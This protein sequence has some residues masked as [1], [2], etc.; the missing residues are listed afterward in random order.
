M[1]IKVVRDFAVD[2][3][4]QLETPEESAFLLAGWRGFDT[5]GTILA[6]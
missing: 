2:H 6:D 1:S 4:R 3:H 5:K